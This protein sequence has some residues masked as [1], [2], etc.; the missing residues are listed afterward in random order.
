MKLEK[1]KVKSYDWKIEWNGSS[2]FELTHIIDSRNKHTVNKATTTCT[3]R[4]W[5]LVGIPCQHAV[6][7]IY[8]ESEDPEKY[9]SHWYKKEM[10]LKAYKYIIQCVAGHEHWPNTGKER[11]EPPAFKK[12]PGRP[13]INRKKDKDEVKKTSASKLPRTGRVMSCNICKEQG[14]NSRKCPQRTTEVLLFV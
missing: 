6:A 1:N 5:D 8:H 10:Y 3:C 7:A 13:K 14:H 9:I 11:I 12:M 2:G 4:E